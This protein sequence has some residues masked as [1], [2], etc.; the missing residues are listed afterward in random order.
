MAA[1]VRFAE[2]CIRLDRHDRFKESLKRLR[3]LAD[4]LGTSLSAAD[5]QRLELA[6][7]SRADNLELSFHIAN[8]TFEEGREV[9]AE[10]ERRLQNIEEGLDFPYRNDYWY[11]LAI[12]NFGLGEYDR[13]LHWINRIVNESDQDVQQGVYGFARIFSLIVHLELGNIELLENAV[14]SLRRYFSRRD[15]L[16]R[17]EE[18]FLLFLRNIRNSIDRV[19]EIDACRRLLQ[20]VIALEEDPYESR[21]FQFFDVKS[22]LRGK[23]EGKTFAEV[24]RE[25]TETERKEREEP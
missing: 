3:G 8:G 9:V 18:A 24:V 22:W 15:R 25:N 16:Y 14:R 17:F 20:T 1:L 7:G 13:S 4:S 2:I 6:A 12:F 10:I 11:N 19:G 23:I 21:V 5:R